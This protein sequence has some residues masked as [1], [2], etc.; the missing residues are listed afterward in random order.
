ML[1]KKFPVAPGKH[2]HAWPVGF[3]G[4]L[5]CTAL[6]V[7]QLQNTPFFTT[8]S[9]STSENPH[10]LTECLMPAPT[11]LHKKIISMLIIYRK[12]AFF[13]QMAKIVPCRAMGWTCQVSKV[14]RAV[15][16]FSPRAGLGGDP[17]STAHSCN[18]LPSY[19]MS[20]GASTQVS[21]HKICVFLYK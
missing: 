5:L 2:L 4:R 17:D 9:I 7:Q 14:W 11:N 21:A 12:S 1:L 6:L 16:H 10:L 13:K 20:A 19:Q 3:I 18:E 8:V 15:T